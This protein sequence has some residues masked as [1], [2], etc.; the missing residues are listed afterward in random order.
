MAS[1]SNSTA[2]KLQKLSKADLIWCI[3]EYEKHSLGWPS[4][5]S[6][7][8]ELKHKKNIENIDRCE[9]LAKK[10]HDKRMAYCELI[11]PYEGKPIAEMPKQ[12]FEKAI[13]LLREA[14]AADD[15]WFRLSGIKR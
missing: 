15:E 3:L 8:A 4:V 9:T 12:V 14:E 13:E 6:I 10:A 7:L 11:A 2:A 5:D 1:S